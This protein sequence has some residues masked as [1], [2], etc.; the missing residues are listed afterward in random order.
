MISETLVDVRGVSK[1]FD[2]HSRILNNVSFS[3]RRGEMVALIGASGSG[4][5][6]LIRLLAGLVPADRTE[7]SAAGVINLFGRPMQQNGRVAREA[8]DLRAR[9]GVIFQQFN[10]VPRL[11]VLTNVCLG[12]LGRMPRL[13][14]TFG[15]FTFDE[16]RRAM[17]ALDRVGIAQHALKRGS[18]LSGGQQ[19]RAA[20]ARTL[21][22]GAELLI[23]D[24]PIASLDPGS[25]RRVMDIL[26]DMNRH[27]GITILVSLHQVDYALRYCP[28][29]IALKAGEVVYDGPSCE[30]TPEMLCDIYGAEQSELFP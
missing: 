27:D 7:T 11:A 24:E 1:R 13:R 2:R 9:I 25:A 8:K 6:T 15:R 10:L 19:Q 22:Q 4:K 28:R 30:L 20:I 23:A 29:T 17:A 26:S 21:V 18:Q 3:L 16:K 12:F 5:S 14:G